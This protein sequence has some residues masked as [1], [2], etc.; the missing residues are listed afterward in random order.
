[1]SADPIAFQ[2][3]P[4]AY[5][6]LACRQVFP[7]RTTLPCAAFED[8]FEAVR[9]GQAELAMIPI[10][11]SVN[12]RVADVH[13]LLPR[14]GLN[15]IGEHFHRVQHHL[16]VLPGAALAD[17]RTVHSHVQGLGQC[18]A[19]IRRLGLKPVVEADTAGSARMVAE[20]G[21]RSRAAIASA[22]AGE[23]Y[24]LE[25]LQSG[26]EDEPHN[27]TRF[28]IMAREPR[29]PPP[30]NGPTVTSFLFEVRSVPAA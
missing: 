22:L 7:D 18:R 10:E 20:R 30:G 1:M 27:T 4:G 9:D 8:A 25:S 3:A 28:L 12:G 15:I 13:R 6:D 2:G 19:L 23:I 11:N 24:G 21:D 16:L 17:L 14:S 26:I 5:S 29:W